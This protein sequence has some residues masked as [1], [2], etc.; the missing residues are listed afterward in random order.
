MD[1]PPD[2][3]HARY[4]QQATW[5]APLRQRA[6]A[7]AGLSKSHRIL[8]VGSGTG[9]ITADLGRQTAAR[10]FGID[11]D[12]EIIGFARRQDPGTR[13]ALAEADWLPFAD[14]P[15]DAAVCHFLL[16]WAE[17]PQHVVLEMAR[18][19]RPGGWV[20]CLAEPDYGGRID[21]PALL[22]D[23]GRLQEEALRRQ[24]ADP[25]IGR[26]LR[27][28]LFGAGLAEVQ[29]GVLGGEWQGIASQSEIE[30]EW[31]TLEGDLEGLMSAGD[32]AELRRVYRESA[33]D[34][35]QMVFVP[36]FYGFGRKP[37]RR[38]S[39]LAPKRP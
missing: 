1:R 2:F 25:H 12:R 34:G 16:L 10:V 9:V 8:E 13:V 26:R 7:L 24:G 22:A 17:D 5:T 23:A 37:G 33:G 28:L 19:T 30:S 3:W 38:S 6:Y 35:T 15:F 32:L 4:L 14:G 18:V 11:R 21:H 39:P 20:L 27:E 29:V 36:T 31:A